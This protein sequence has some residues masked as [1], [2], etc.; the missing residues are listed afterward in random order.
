MVQM[1]LAQMSQKLAALQGLR[2]RLKCALIDIQAD[3]YL[4]AKSH[5]FLAYGSAMDSKAAGSK[6]Q[7]RLYL[8]SLAI[9]GLR[10]SI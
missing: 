3:P 9:A 4:C 6:L 7:Q 1:L 2:Q 10:K 5:N 8:F